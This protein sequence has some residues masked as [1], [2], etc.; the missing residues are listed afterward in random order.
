MNT[1]IVPQPTPAKHDIRQRYKEVFDSLDTQAQERELAL[2]FSWFVGVP[3]DWKTTL[4]LISGNID[5]PDDGELIEGTCS[6]I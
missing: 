4:K 1:T 6:V 5:S 3:L 2:L